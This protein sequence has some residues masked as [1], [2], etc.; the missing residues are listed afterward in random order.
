MDNI[1]YLLVAGAGVA[2][3][4]FIANKRL[5]QRYFEDLA[6]ETEEAKD[7]YR[8]KYLKQAAEEGEDLGVSEAAISAADALL[9]YSG[10][11]IGP[12]ILTEELT[13]TIERAVA[14]GELD[15][16]PPADAEK[17]DWVKWA[18]A[19]AGEK[20]VERG[21]LTVFPEGEE[22]KSAHP[23]GFD[24]A[25]KL[26]EEASK[27]EPPEVRSDDSNDEAGRSY[28]DI[29]AESFQS[30]EPEPEKPPMGFNYN[31]VSAPK[32]PPKPE[33]VE[34]EP[35]GPYI[36]TAKDFIESGTG[37]KQRSVTY[38]AGDDIL[39]GE[40]DHVVDKTIRMYTLG[41]AVLQK[42][43]DGLGGVDT[44]YVRSPDA[45]Y[46]FEITRSTGKYSEE[47]GPID[48]TG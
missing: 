7:F 44:I 4:Y 23:E 39:A 9:K 27:V 13:A 6:R 11:K 31:K 18:D 8:R 29:P 25:E 48:N 21:E 37:F 45:G 35:T 34:A 14:G 22:P 33:V 32:A 41:K 20:A 43:K 24:S 26:L 16:E 17:G 10:L 46:E 5:E 38:Y 12:S 28:T 3:G 15:P 40:T 19:L 2:V 1:K 47:V 30:P 36:I 42:L